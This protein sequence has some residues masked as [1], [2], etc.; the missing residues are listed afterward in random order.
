MVN[1]KNLAVVVAVL[2]CGLLVVACGGSGGSQSTAQ[3]GAASGG[4]KGQS[5]LKVGMILTGA[6]ND[7]D[8]NYVGYQALKTV[9]QQESAKI[10][11]VE[12]TSVADA[13]QNAKQL[14][15]NGYNVVIF[16]S[17]SYL[18]SALA[19]ARA[20]SDVSISAQNATGAMSGQPANMSIV[21][22]RFEPGEYALGYAASKVA[23]GGKAC[24]MS[25]LAVPSTIAAGN[26]AIRGMKA[27]GSTQFGYT[28]TGD[29]DDAAKARQAAAAMI[30]GGCKAF[31]VHLNGAVSGVVQAIHD[32]GKNIP[33]LGL[34]TDKK[35]MDPQ[36]YVGS[37][38]FNFDKV[39]Q[40]NIK[41]IQAGKR[42]GVYDL[43]QEIRL[44]P[45]YH[46]SSAQ[47]KDIQHVFDQ[48]ASGQI[49]VPSIIDKIKVP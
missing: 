16:D 40:Q 22:L 34:Y 46:V 19:L 48:V 25:G 2:C 7:D 17:S 9:E 5:N 28:F 38:E 49:K 26:A 27:A 21:Q 14:V 36:N 15:A 29:F 32:S 39:Y 6:I 42:N 41:D 13:T 10:G 12:H 4:T 43:G 1:V 47:K 35:E 23:D 18:N 37:Y 8:W 45:L 11:Y 44:T 3:T 24:W 31:V 33:W 30:N 20:S